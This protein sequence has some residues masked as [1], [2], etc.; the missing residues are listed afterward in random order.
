[1]QASSSADLQVATDVPAF[2]VTVKQEDQSPT[3][4]I[5]IPI[6]GTSNGHD[7]TSDRGLVRDNIPGKSFF[8][9]ACIRQ[10][11][12]TEI[13]RMDSD[14]II[15]FSDAASASHTTVIGSLSQSLAPTLAN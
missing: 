11:S 10:P 7:S 14:S 4:L 2:I 3:S 15:P 6:N 5:T 12:S 1:M 9:T 13:S 8:F